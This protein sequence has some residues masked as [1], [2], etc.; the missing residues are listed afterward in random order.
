MWRSFTSP[1]EDL[2]SPAGRE[3]RNAVA[4]AINNQGE[5]VGE[6]D[7]GPY[8]GFSILRAFVWDDEHGMRDLNDLIPSSRWTLIY[9]LDVNNAGQIVG[10]GIN[11]HGYT[12]AFLLSPVP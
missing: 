5:V 9:A 11:P 7:V 6:A 12:E 8:D 2:G 4:Y 1:I 3:V 10:A